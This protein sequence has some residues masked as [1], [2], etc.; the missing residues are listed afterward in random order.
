[1]Q[2]IMKNIIIMGSG[3]SGTSM[4]AGILA[5][6]GYFQGNYVLNK[7]RINNPFGNFEDQEVN[8]INEQLLSQVIPGPEMVN[9]VLTHRDRPSDMQ[10]WL[11]RLP[12]GTVIPPM[13]EYTGNIIKLTGQKPF[14]FKDP[15]FSY[16][17]PVWRPYLQ[18]TVFVCVFRNPHKTAQSILKQIQDAP[19]LNGLEMDYAMAL[20]VWIKM[21]S[22]I[23]ETHR[24]EGEWLFLHYDQA[25]TDTGLDELSEFTGASVNRDFPLKSLRRDY[26]EQPIPKDA[27]AIYAQ[28]CELAGFDAG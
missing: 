16:T 17:L 20:D 11:G 9:G 18:D 28:L 5:Q 7:G 26:H 13:A 15:R 10:R 4:T 22:H 25:L 6:S 19:Y 24:H 21:Y 3:R 14:Y 27:A 2:S 12:V 8:Y 1:M 23:L